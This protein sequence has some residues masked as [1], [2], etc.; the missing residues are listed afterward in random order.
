MS[1]IKVFKCRLKDVFTEDTSRQRIIDTVKRMNILTFNCYHFIRFIIIKLIENNKPIPNLTAGVMKRIFNCFRS[2]GDTYDDQPWISKTELNKLMKEFKDITKVG[3][4]NLEYLSAMIA[5]E[6][7]K[8]ITAFK[9]NITL[10]F[11]KYMFQWINA[12]FNVPVIKHIPKEEFD[13][14]TDEEKLKYRQECNELKKKKTLMMKEL[15]PIKKDIMEGTLKS[16]EIYHKFINDTRK[17]IEFNGTILMDDV[18][19]NYMKYLT[20]MVKMNKELEDHQMKLFQPIPLRTDISDKYVMFNTNTI[21]YIFGKKEHKALNTTEVWNKYVNLNKKKLKFKGYHFNDLIETDGIAISVY[22]RENKSYAKKQASAKI[23]STAST[24]TKIN[25]RDMS[26]EDYK[27]FMDGKV[28]KKIDQE[29]KSTANKKKL[30]EEYKKL[31]KDEQL[32]IRMKMREFNYLSDALVDVEMKEKLKLLLLDGKV[33]VVDP[34]KRDPATMLGSNNVRFSYTSG[35][36][37][38]DTKRN[39]MTTLRQ[40]KMDQIMKECDCEKDLEMLSKTNTKTTYLEKYK[41]YLKIKYGLINKLTEAK[42]NELSDYLNKLKWFSFVNTKRHEDKILNEIDRT[43]GRDAVFIVG[44]WSAIDRIKGTPMPSMRIKRLLQRNHI[45]LL[46]DEYNT[47]KL[48]HTDYIEMKHPVKKYEYKTKEGEIKK[49]EKELYPVFSFKTSKGTQ[50][51]INRD[52]NATLNMMTIV[53]SEIAGNGR[54]TEFKRKSP[55]K[56]LKTNTTKV[57]ETITLALK[58]C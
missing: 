54:P 28:Q 2:G 26:P 58:W 44:D 36:R 55:S 8:I 10:N 52:Y 17:L 13:K 29:E 16:K 48:N 18:K 51:Y 15:S 6:S 40:N 43:Y 25:K 45:V 41:E 3:D 37:L 46:I 32:K 19:K 42:R 7:T 47:S 57:Q 49:Y 53:K 4:L 14:K 39:K 30:K 27:K 31:P 50:G 33:I 35:R 22:F 38:R 9:N 11:Y 24:Q 23:K 56:D 34:G 21:R 5:D 12:K 1:E 20:I